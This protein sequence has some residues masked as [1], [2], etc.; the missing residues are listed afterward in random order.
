MT[1]RRLRFLLLFYLVIGAGKTAVCQNYIFAQLTGTPINSTGWVFSGDAKVTNIIG[2]ADTEVML[3]RSAKLDDGGVFFSQPINLAFCNKWIAEFDFRMYDGTGADGIAFCFLDVPPTNF[4][5]GGGLGIPDVANGLKVCFDT[6]NNCVDPG[7][8]DSVTVHQDMPKIEIRWGKGYDE[9]SNSGEVIYGECL[10]LPTL[11]NKNGRLD[12]IRGPNYNRAK[13]EYDTGR[14]S[15]YVNDTLYISTYAPGQFNFTGYM[16]FTAGTG[17][18]YDNQSIKNVI[19]Y[20]EMPVPNAGPPQAFCPYDTVALGG[21][22]NPLYIYAWSPPVG[23]SDTTSSAPLLHLSNDSTIAGL[24][25]YYLKTAFADNPGCTSLDSVTVKVFANPAVNFIMPGICLSDV[26]GQFYDSSYTQDGET[27]PFTY[28]WNFG[29]AYASPPG[30]PDNSTLQNPAHN[31]SAAANYLMSLRVTNSEG[32]VDSAVKTFTVNGTDPQAVFQ[33]LGP[34]ELCSN[35]AVQLNNNSTVNFGSIVAVQ[36]YWGDTAGV[37]HMDSMP[38]PGKVY[39]HNYPNPVTSSVATYTIRMIAASGRTCQDET[40]Q[41]VTVKP[42]PHAVFATVPPYC[43]IDTAVT[44]S[45]GSEL[46]GL[47][48]VWSFS[49]RG[50]S[51][52]SVL[53]PLRAGAGYDTLVY[54]YSAT[55]GCSDTAYQTVYIQSLPKVRATDDTAVVDGQPLQLN[56][57]SSD[58]SGDVFLW[59]PPE[60]L[61]D[62]GIADPVAILGANVDTLNYL[63]TAMDSLGCTGSAGVKVIVF[64]TGPG[65]FVPNAF[66]P[67][68]NS[69]PIFRPIPV[70]IAQLLYFRVYNRLG[71]L[72]YST[73]RI[74]EG[75]DGLVDGK[76]QSTGVFVWVGAATTYSGK[77]ILKKG[78]VILVR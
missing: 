8:Y 35:A 66:T 25:T 37:S 43:D 11:S 17:G 10:P 36:I 7:N 5:D 20:T 39:S 15:V 6:W 13:I 54:V 49:G 73:S 23:L 41:L 29:D 65:L 26:V 52:G 28:L 45:E 69:N 51:E 71:Q 16:G 22:A 4:V 31:Y 9:V 75:W 12:F 78:T 27:L 34:T 67:G 56:A 3:T 58:R 24:H 60:G 18:F 77:E 30:N 42:A 68:R 44:L 50:V 53:N 46:T 64:R 19:I 76:L 59:T 72:V 62:P 55:N 48:G 70:G 61:N 47:G 40:D 74:G 38:Y 14:I 2:S 1:I 57:Y 63:V 33:V 32:C 21:A